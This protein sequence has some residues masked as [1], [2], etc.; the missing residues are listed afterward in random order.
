VSKLG[1]RE[2]WDWAGGT[3]KVLG[4]LETVA[5]LTIDVGGGRGGPRC[6]CLGRLSQLGL[7][8]WAIRPRL[9][10]RCRRIEVSLSKGVGRCRS[11]RMQ[12]LFELMDE[13]RTASRF[14][15]RRL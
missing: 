6:R 10:P 12:V 8:P 3:G 7:G 9:S 14:S 2:D 13:A 4:G 15:G 5:A 11:A 1:T